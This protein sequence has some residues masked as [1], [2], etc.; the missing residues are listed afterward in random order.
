MKKGANFWVSYADLMTSLFFIMLVLYVVTFIKMKIDEG[1]LRVQA[2]LVEE[3]KNVEKALS[4]IDSTYFGY[5]DINKRYKLKVDIQF[6][7]NNA[8]INTLDKATRDQLV[9]AGKDLYDKIAELTKENKNI[10]YLLVIEGNTERYNDNFNRI[11]DIGYRLSYD[12]ALALFN[13]WKENGIDFSQL[14]NQCEVMIAGSGYFG[15]SRE[16]HEPNNKRFSIQVTSK[17]GKF[18][19]KKNQIN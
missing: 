18:L 10:D 14:N 2:G 3:I 9:G 7:P 6:P 12:R 5:D 15:Q 4:E 13:F 1:I 19:Q 16:S 11:P 8:N 17:V